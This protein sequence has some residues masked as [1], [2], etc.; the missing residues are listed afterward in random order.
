MQ[1]K[2]ALPLLAAVV[3]AS[4]AA[5]PVVI[6]EPSA[7]RWMY[8]A[9]STPGTRGQASTFSALPASSGLDDRF[10][11]F[12]IRFDTT[13]AVPAGL[14]AS[15]YR[16]RS[17][18]LTATIGQDELFRYDP[19]ADPLTSFGTPTAPPTEADPDLGRP[20]ELHGAGFRNGFT[21]QTFQENSANGGS[22][23]GTRNAFPMGFDDLGA[24]RDVSNNITD[25]F[26]SIPWAI[27]KTNDVEPTDLVPL[28]TEFTFEIDAS[29]PGVSS[30]LQESLSSG[31]VWLSLSSLHPA[32]QQ[33]GEFVAWLTRDDAIHQ[34]FGGLAPSLTLDVAL[35]IPL[36]LTRES[37]T[38]TLTWPEF[39]GYTHQLRASSN[40]TDWSTEP[41][42]T[43]AA[44]TDGSGT[45]TETTTEARRFYQLEIL[46][47]SP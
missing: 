42:H 20:L 11:F 29:L 3:G 33:G 15:S 38:S 32:T 10:G 17:I 30:Y 14:P 16:I 25:A 18:T 13:A 9:N 12:L 40:L 43:H 39:A 7:D 27:G 21:A 1:M 23:P 4:A 46:P 8:V 28:E 2:A 47:T 19:S 24:A 37:N 22:A 34:L 35:D 31:Q 5:Q 6:P 44:T 41:I 45:F 26:D 36:T